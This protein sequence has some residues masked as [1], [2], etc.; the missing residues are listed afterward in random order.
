MEECFG[1]HSTGLRRGRELKNRPDTLYAAVNLGG[2]VKIPA[3]VE[4]QPCHRKCSVCTA[5]L[6]KSVKHTLR[7]C[8]A[9]RG[10]RGQFENCAATTGARANPTLGGYA[11][12]IPC[13]IED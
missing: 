3:G 1:P 12:Q 10:G 9:R 6:L 5:I 11:I 2:P 7:P 4:D 13:A 8:S